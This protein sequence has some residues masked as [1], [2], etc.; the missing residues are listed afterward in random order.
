MARLLRLILSSIIAPTEVFFEPDVR[1]DK[2]VAASHF[3][4]FEFC[5]SGAS[6]SP[7]DGGGC[8]GVAADDRLEG[9]FNCEVEM[10]C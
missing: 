3:S 9:K 8:P 5:D 2:E 1:D 7:G 10:G 6:I 4:D